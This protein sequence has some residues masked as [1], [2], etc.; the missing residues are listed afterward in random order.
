MKIPFITRFLSFALFA[1]AFAFPAAAEVSLQPYFY[2]STGSWPEA[3]AIAD[4]NNDGRNDVVMN[5]S[6]YFDPENDYNLK[7]F[8]QDDFGQLQSPV[9]YSLSYTSA[10]RPQSIA[11][12]DLNG[13]GLKDVAVGFDRDRIEIFLQYTDGTLFSSEIIATPMSTRI[14]AADLNGDG[15]D[16]IAGIGWGGEAVGVFYQGEQGINHEPETHYA[17]HGG[18]DDMV[19]G[20]I[21]GDGANDIVV[22]SGQSY[23]FDNLAV[24]ASDGEGGL[25]PAVFYD[26]GD[27]ELTQAVT[28]GDLNA[29]GLNDVAVTFGG[30]MPRASLA[31]FHQDGSGL[32]Q[33]PQILSSYEVPQTIH[34]ADLNQDATDDLLVLHGGWYAIGVY[35]QEP[36]GT[37]ADEV[38]FSVPYASHY[39]RQGMD[40]GDINSDGIPDV[41]VAD[42]NHGLVVLLGAE[43][44]PKT[45]PVAAAG[46]D[47]VVQGNAYVQL[48]GS[49]SSDSDGN[50]VAYRWSQVSG[51]P[52]QLNSSADGYANFVAPTPPTGSTIELVIELEVEDNDGLTARDTVTVIVE[53]NIAPVAIAGV[54]Q[55]VKQNSVVE[56]N[57][58]ES[59]DLDGSITSY[60]WTQLSGPAVALA[61][62]NTAIAS[63]T[64]PKLKSMKQAELVFE[65]AIT[66][67]LGEVSTDQVTITV[68]K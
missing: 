33:A 39:N 4:L 41:V 29:D 49:L 16:D 11:V 59:V 10:D 50:I 30:N 15:L 22:M 52:V 57:G 48:N 19:L 66:D 7:V 17:P 24:V 25:Q 34:A 64:A 9:S 36:A 46:P 13:D 31:I 32:L 26:L 12:G 58:T 1:F 55:T 23:A 37:L 20:D 3:V 18:Y 68:V 35:E 40:V 47:L 63:F 53:A 43:A 8:L 38:L 51:T 56:L 61:N 60:R 21:N 14:A 45:P 65:L 67:N 42:Y 44:E 54:G 5:T 2:Y 28:I 62:A 27:D 6:Y